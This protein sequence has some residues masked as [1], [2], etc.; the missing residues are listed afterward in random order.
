M[1]ARRLWSPPEEE[2]VVA[3]AVTPSLPSQLSRTASFCWTRLT[4]CHLPS[5]ALGNGASANVVPE[6]PR[7]T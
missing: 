5:A 3:A 6:L 7:E 2:E 1:K 4:R